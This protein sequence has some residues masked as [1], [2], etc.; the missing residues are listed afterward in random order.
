M[1]EPKVSPRKRPQA[2][3]KPADVRS[4]LKALIARREQAVAE[5]EQMVERYERRVAMEERAYGAMSPLRRM[6]AG[7]KPDHHRAVEYIHYVKKPMERARE[8]R[9]EIAKYE[10]MLS[11]SLPAELPSF[12]G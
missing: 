12:E 7:K 10:A 1:G 6:L 5:I 11:G 8:L 2:A 4:L 3:G 9:A